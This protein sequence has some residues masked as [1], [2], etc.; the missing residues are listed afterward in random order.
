MFRKTTTYKQ[1]DLQTTVSQHLNDTAYQLFSDSQAW[2]NQFFKQITQKID[3]TMFSELFSQDMGAPNASIRQLIA[4]M[5]LKEGHG[6]SDEQLFENC[7]FNLLVRKSLGLYDL[8]E[9]TPSESTYYLLRKRILEHKKKSTVDLFEKLFQSITKEQIAEFNVSGKSVRMD[10]K[11]IGSNIAYFSRYELIHKTL[12]LYLKN[13][14]IEV[15]SL[16]T[17]AEQAQLKVF[18]S[19]DSS[20]TIYRSTRDEIQNKLKDLGVLIFKIIQL[21]NDD[22]NEQFQIMQRVF[23][24]HYNLQDNQQV[25]VKAK[26]ELSAQSIQSP[27]DTECTYRKKNNES[28]KGYSHNV[29]ETCHDEGLKLIT[30]VQTEPAS[31]ADNNFA[32]TAIDNSQN[33]L[34]DKI[35]NI[36]ADGAY[37]S[38]ENQE[39][40]K[41]NH[42]NLYLT[43]FQGTEGRYDLSTL[44]EKLQI[45]DKQTGEIL[46]AVATNGSKYRISTAKGYRYFSE[47]EIEKFHI[48]K[49][50]E[51]WPQT[52]KNKRNNV[53]ATIY[54]LA[55]HLRKDKTR[56]RGMFQNMSWAKC[57]CLWINFVRIENYCREI[58]KA[59]TSGVKCYLRLFNLSFPDFA[60]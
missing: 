55:Y 29:T 3:E 41:I 39:Y 21:K 5:I 9:A 8:T 10:S 53:E 56:Y 42:A 2:H 38:P 7:R 11:L 33:L 35:E 50:I 19:E 28:T 15:L 13:N 60:E 20:K 1:L 14:E 49:Q 54:Q 26:E 22:K 30:G 31:F 45:T 27:H 12:C 24:E 34:Q 57:R 59:T 6:W 48:R 51:Q 40:A 58:Q 52:V 17:P 32:E 4:M 25:S 47:K 16:L 23:S 37:N 44:V 36:H 46:T 43:G 18:L